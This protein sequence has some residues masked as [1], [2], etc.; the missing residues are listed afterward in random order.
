[1]TRFFSSFNPSRKTPITFLQNTSAHRLSLSY[2]G[3]SQNTNISYL[4]PA[5]PVNHAL[6]TAKPAPNSHM[7][8]AATCLMWPVYSWLCRCST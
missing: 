3:H 4:W 2:N 1:L 7:S 6:H 5:G 8:L